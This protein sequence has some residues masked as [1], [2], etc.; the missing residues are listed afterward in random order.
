MYGYLPIVSLYLFL[1]FPSLLLSFPLF[2][3]FSRII[4]Q[5][6]REHLEQEHRGLMSP[7][8]SKSYCQSHKHASL[9]GRQKGL[10]MDAYIRFCI[11]NLS[12]LMCHKAGMHCSTPRCSGLHCSST[13]GLESIWNLPWPCHR[14]S[15]SPSPSKT[16]ALGNLKGR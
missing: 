12:C 8:P 1:H 9:R 11:L 14:P 3:H 7:C 2:V 6:N 4:L 16:I 5:V 10:P 13:Q 15:L